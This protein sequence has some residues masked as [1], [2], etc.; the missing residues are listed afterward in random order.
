MKNKTIFGTYEWAVKNANYINGCSHDCKYCYSKE[1]AIRYKRKQP[2]NWKVEEINP[3]QLVKKFKKVDGTIMFPSSHDI[4]PDNLDSSIQFI[5]KLLDPGNNVLIVTKPHLSVIMAICDTFKP[6][7]RKILFRFTIGSSNSKIL[8]F[9]EPNAPSFEERLESMKFAF[10]NGFKTSVSCEPMLDDKTLDLVYILEPF[11][12]DSIWIGKAN[13]LI[14]R[15]KM[16]GINDPK[17]FAEA[18]KLLKIQNN[19]DILLL[20]ES[21]RNNKKIKWKDSIKKI[22]NLELASASGLD[23]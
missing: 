12:T 15:L 7:K 8:R 10:N 14:R 20:Y 17:T 19:T 4:S 13:F 5:Q 2:N 16:N 21:L 3:T 18:N 22:A 1:M 9:W 6:Y 23:K 11:V